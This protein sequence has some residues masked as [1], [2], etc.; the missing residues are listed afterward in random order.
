MTNK[1]H[2]L[3]AAREVTGSCYLLEAGDRR[4][5]L[6]CGMHQGVDAEEVGDTGDFPF[7]PASLDAVVLSH[8][9]LDHSGML[10]RLVHLGYRGPIYCTSGTRHLLGILLEDAARIYWRERQ[11]A[12]E[13]DGGL[14]EPLYQPEDVARV[15]ALCRPV[16]YHRQVEVAPWI[17]VRFFD[18]GHILGAAI[19]ELTVAGQGQDRV[20]V[21]S[22]DLGNPETALMRRWEH[23]ARA[24]V[25][26]ME[27]T[28]GDRNHRDMAETLAEFRHILAEAAKRGGNILIPAF[29]VGRTQELLFHLGQLYHQGTLE[30][31]QV[32]LDTPMGHAVTDV[33]SRSLEQL[34]KDDVSSMAA[35]GADDL[36]KFLPILRVTE[37]VEDSMAINRF[38][39]GAIIIAGSGMCTGGRILHHLRHNLWRHSSHVV[40]VG[41]QA[42]GTLGRALVDGDR[43]VRL[44]QHTVAV[45][46]TI[47][48]LGGFSAHAGQRQLLEWAGGFRGRPAF[49]LV[50][51]EPDSMSALA[52]RMREELEIE[53][54]MP[55]KGAVIEF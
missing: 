53:A 7:D 54:R 21:F 12:D 2:F 15:L 36:Y 32:F 19:V 18:A 44:F 8:A 27:S 46:A 45:N 5:L 52:R 42:R 24:D 9:H 38:R 51:G 49:Y 29:A 14:R 50:H 17:Q 30:G 11:E 40:I 13:H 37:S 16:D 41:F 31:W 20:L 33:Y 23:P 43:R 28:Y 47:H 55:E 34:N 6:D 48:T 4:V 39:G 25:V 3:G 35:E 10:P 22:G 26:L 1:L